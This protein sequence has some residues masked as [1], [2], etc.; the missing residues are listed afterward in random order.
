MSSFRSEA[1]IIT[2]AFNRTNACDSNYHVHVCEYAMI[3]R[4]CA[5]HNPACTTYIL[6]RFTVQARALDALRPHGPRPPSQSRYPS[7]Q[8]IRRRRRDETS[9]NV[10]ASE[11][12]CDERRRSARPFRYII[13]LNTL[14][15]TGNNYR[16]PPPFRHI[17]YRVQYQICMCM[18]VYVCAVYIY[19]YFVFLRCVNNPSAYACV[20]ACLSFYAAGALG[21]DPWLLPRS[22]ARKFERTHTQ[23][24]IHT[25][26][27]THLHFS[28]GVVKPENIFSLFSV[29]VCVRV[30]VFP[31][32][33]GYLKLLEPA[34]VDKYII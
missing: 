17:I 7:T 33:L 28:K 27:P 2:F 4:P 32:L 1:N 20:Y 34:D 3:A 10:G 14:R 18:Y 16:A 26:Q 31:H 23:M 13:F 12:T 22:S 25:L 5:L 29:G 9:E 11:R 30:V 8:S 19:I 21:S 15:Q 6:T 24:E